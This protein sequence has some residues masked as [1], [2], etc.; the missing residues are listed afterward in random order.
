MQDWVLKYLFLIRFLFSIVSC[1]IQL[2]GDESRD[3]DEDYYL[4][5]SI[6]DAVVVS[7]SFS[8]IYVQLAED[9]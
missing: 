7:V 1:A 8:F 2:V 5:I 3:V 4:F 9:V 6:L